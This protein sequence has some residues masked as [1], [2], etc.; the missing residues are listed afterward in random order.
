MAKDPKKA[1]K[2]DPVAKSRTASTVN[3]AKVVPK[4]VQTV[5]A[6]TAGKAVTK[7]VSSTKPTT[8]GKSGAS[9]K[10]G[11]AATTARVTSTGAA[12]TKTAPA[13]AARKPTSAPRVNP[14]AGAKTLA[15]PAKKM[16]G[17]KQSSVAEA[18][19]PE[20]RYRMVEEAAYYIA[21]RHGFAGDNHAY[22][23]EAEKE[24]E[25]QLTTKK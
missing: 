18:I 24:I 20:Q 11:T 16:A 17:T 4:A 6:T 15:S 7:L 19:T 8:T 5:A 23:F 2:A 21:E 1:T 13:S 10:A 3:K 14:T 9:A 12:Q 22:W 25:A